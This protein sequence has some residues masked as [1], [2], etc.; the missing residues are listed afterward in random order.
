MPPPLTSRSLRRRFEQNQE[1][2]T[3]TVLAILPTATENILEA[4]PVE[5]ALA[6]LQRD[7]AE[8]LARSVGPS[9]VSTADLPSTPPSI[10]DGDTASLQ[11]SSF[12]HASRLAD[13]SAVNGEPTLLSSPGRAKRNKVQLWNEIKIQCEYPVR[14]YA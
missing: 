7:K 2:C 13:G 5:R 10:A 4:L 12:V 6:E 11:S 1:D 14:D 9:E 8:R 3:F